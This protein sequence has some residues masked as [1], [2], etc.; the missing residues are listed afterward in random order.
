MN[1][2]ELQSRFRDLREAFAVALGKHKERIL[3]YLE[4]IRKLQL[5]VEQDRS[6][7]MSKTRKERELR[8]IQTVER[9]CLEREKAHAELS[10]LVD[11]VEEIEYLM[12]RGAR[13]EDH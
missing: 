13:T 6:E 8:V 5:E 7:T 12:M 3:G 2:M 9:S 1:L 4:E 11:E 10:R